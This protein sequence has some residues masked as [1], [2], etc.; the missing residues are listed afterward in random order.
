[1]AGLQW[2]WKSGEGRRASP[3]PFLSLWKG[4]VVGDPLLS[5][6]G[7]SGLR[8]RGSEKMLLAF[9]SGPVKLAPDRVSSP[10]VPSKIFLAKRL[11][12]AYVSVMVDDV[13][14]FPFIS[15]LPARAKGKV[16]L[17][18]EVWAE[19][20]ALQQAKGFLIPRSFV[21]E[22]TGLSNQRISQLVSRGVLEEVRLRAAR[23]ITED[24]FNRWAAEEHVRGRPVKC[25][26]LN[27]VGRLKLLA[28]AGQNF[29][30][31][32]PALASFQKKF[33]V[34]RKKA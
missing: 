2:C 3:P 23:F 30:D 9:F 5:L 19:V 15:E 25:D 8:N 31:D 12:V 34:E 28:K 11:V 1:M 6:L 20:K 29:I 18:R 26:G 4:R 24:S 10:G 33:K 21:P 16:A 13:L 27:V 22:L 17:A 14:E 32:Q 7:L